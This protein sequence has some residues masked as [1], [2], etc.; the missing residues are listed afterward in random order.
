MRLFGVL[1][2]SIG[3][4]A[5]N[6][7]NDIQQQAKINHLWKVDLGEDY[8]D[9][10]KELYPFSEE[11]LW[12]AE[13]K[14]NGLVDKYKD[15]YIYIMQLELPDDKKIYLPQ[16]GKYMYQNVLDLKVGIRRK[17]RHLVI[18]QDEHIYDQQVSY[19][20]VFHMTDD[21]QEYEENFPIIFKYLTKC[22][23]RNNGFLSIDD[24]VELDK[25]RPEIGG[26][27]N[28]FWLNEYIMFKT[29]TPSSFESYTEIFNMY[30]MQKFGLPF[31]YYD[32]ATYKGNK[33]VITYN[34]INKDEKFISSAQLACADENIDKL[35]LVR[36][37]NIEDT[38]SS[39][40]E[41][42]LKN[43]Y[44]YNEN[45]LSEINTLYIYDLMTL[46]P[47]RNP[48]NWGI[49]VNEQNRNI[50]LMAF[51]NGNMLH[52][53]KPRFNQ[54]PS[55]EQSEENL[56]NN[57]TLLLQTYGQNYQEDKVTA[58]LNLYYEG[59]NDEIIDYYMQFITEDSIQNIF[60]EI[61]KDHDF[62]LPDNYKKEILYAFKKFIE[63]FY[64][65]VNKKDNHTLVKRHIMNI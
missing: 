26:S 24:Y 28:K 64:S 3:E 65:R 2:N 1:W 41:F 29:E 20:N 11:E 45:I 13:Y 57:H 50:R 25:I 32:L 6:A 53:D 10:I 37:C 36:R 55:E 49:I 56:F 9:F 54:I 60:N 16:K 30:L 52:F 21:P 34:F 59:N 51:D 18:P 63:N 47:D 7:I 31:C 23:N 62:T 44:N 14:I 46:Q 33:G 61:E 38:V 42:C 17:Y 48:Y 27:R 35:E 15:N 39:I 12:K 4:S 43:G 58:L 40:K 5:E 19:D 22:A 8:V